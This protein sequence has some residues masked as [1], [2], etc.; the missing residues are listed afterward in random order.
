MGLCPCGHLP[1]FGLPRRASETHPAVKCEQVG[2]VD[3][4]GIRASTHAIV[5][6]ETRFPLDN[7]LRYMQLRSALFGLWSCFPECGEEQTRY[8]IILGVSRGGI[9]DVGA[10]S[11]GLVSQYG[12]AR[13][14]AGIPF[15]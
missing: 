1:R 4:E 8:P 11:W 12:S 13:Q 2:L 10:G 6:S 7:I 3:S 9:W 14:D 15:R 5:N